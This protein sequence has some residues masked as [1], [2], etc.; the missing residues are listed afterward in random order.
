MLQIRPLPRVSPTINKPNTINNLTKNQSSNPFIP[1]VLAAI[2]RRVHHL[3]VRVENDKELASE[4]EQRMQ[5]AQ[6][7]YPSHLCHSCVQDGGEV[8]FP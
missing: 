4:I 2:K 6:I 1:Q 8:Q 5:M 7:R 3:R